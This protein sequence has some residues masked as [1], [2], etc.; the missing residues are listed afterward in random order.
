MWLVPLRYA[1]MRKKWE[2]NRR[3]FF[4]ARFAAFEI[5]GC[6]FE[7]KILQIRRQVFVCARTLRR[8][9]S[10]FNIFGGLHRIGMI[11][12]M[13]REDYGFMRNITSIFIFQA[14]KFYWRRCSSWSMIWNICIECRY[15]NR[16]FRK[17]VSVNNWRKILYLLFNLKVFDLE[18][19]PI[20][21]GF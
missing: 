21:L 17:L 16:D 2:K 15:W 9:G 3:E 10:E 5:C 11:N 20:S 18:I 4:F 6:V 14:N 13:K 19:A 1:K 8:A 12:R 7:R